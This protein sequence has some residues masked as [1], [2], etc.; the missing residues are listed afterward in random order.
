MVMSLWSSPWGLQA[1][2]RDGPLNHVRS[3]Q[4][5]T[6]PDGAHLVRTWPAAS[7]IKRQRPPDLFK[8]G[9]SYLAMYSR[10]WNWAPLRLWSRPPRAP[11]LCVYQAGR[12]RAEGLE[13]TSRR[14]RTPNTVHDLGC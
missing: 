3:G 4:H 2:F 11:P 14:E 13:Q 9:V 6:V 7:R 1:S 5:G 12:S 8:R 10:R